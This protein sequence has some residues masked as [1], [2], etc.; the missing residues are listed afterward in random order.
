MRPHR[1]YPFRYCTCA[2]HD[3]PQ[4]LHTSPLNARSTDT[5][6][7]AGTSFLHKPVCLGKVNQ[8]RYEKRRRRSR[9]SRKRW[10]SF[11]LESILLTLTFPGERSV[12]E[13]KC[14]L[15]CILEVDLVYI[16]VL[17]ETNIDLTLLNYKGKSW[18]NTGG[19]FLLSLSSRLFTSFETLH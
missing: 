8:Y 6:S 10:T 12:T 18:F 13:L 14:F 2:C 4:P 16:W 5:S 17:V 19:K 7:R 1:T 9:K 11:P 3:S 15:I